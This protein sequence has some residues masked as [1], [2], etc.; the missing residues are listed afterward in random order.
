MASDSRD[1]DEAL[2]AGVDAVV[3]DCDGVLVDSAAS[4]DQSW[5]R[6][7]ERYGL[8]DAVL[9]QAWSGQT[10]LDT[11]TAW[12]PADLVAEGCAAIEEIEIADAGRV[13]RMPGALY[14]LSSLPADRWAIVTSASR[15]L[16]DAR[17]RAA[18][19][20][21]PRVV[22]TADDVVH[23]K[24][25][26]EGYASALRQLGADARRAAVFEDTA[27]GIAAAH[28]AGVACIIRIGTGEPVPP[29][30]AVVPD[31]RWAT[32]EDGL[33]LLR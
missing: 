6:W 31:L 14:L 27:L 33:R 28:A 19:L 4:F 5:R 24:P 26:G 16:F 25:D 15:P 17:L 20:P 8:D 3:F 12:L 10:S 13:T 29:E 22:V 9:L 23:G 7:A 30:A 21:R 2:L 18:G 11:V 32:W 1:P